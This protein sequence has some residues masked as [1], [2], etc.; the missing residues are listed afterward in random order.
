MQCYLLRE[1]LFP[2]SL[3]E[4][5]AAQENYVCILS[6]AEWNADKEKF[7]M[8]I[9]M[10]ISYDLGM[11]KAEVNMDS[12]TGSFSIPQRDALT[13]DPVTF[14]FAMDEKGIVFIDEGNEAEQ[15]VWEIAQSKRWK[16][17]SLERFLYDFLE[18]IIRSDLTLLE[19]REEKLSVMEDEILAGDLDGK[20]E[21]IIDMRNDLK[22]LRVHY[23]QLTDLG[24]ELVEN[25][26][27]FFKKGR[28]RY[29]ELFTKRIM[30]LEDVAAGVR[31]HTVQVRELYQSQQQDKQNHLMGVLTAV[32]TIFLPLTLIA[33][34]YGMN[35]KMPEFEWTYGYP[36]IIGFCALVII[37]WLVIFHKKGW[38]K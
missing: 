11:T 38:F 32:S 33:G 27:G 3:E 4:L 28:I 13:D 31:E 22:T 1:Q 10:E 16:S 5:F 23:E 17:P 12:L 20:M 19:D 21:Q 35:L 6:P 34:W 26:N 30:R 18:S 29:F 14:G 15:L 9:D 25:E 24:Q 8:G 36:I 7:T 37:V 2:V